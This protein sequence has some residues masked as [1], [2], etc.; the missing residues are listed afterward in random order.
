MESEIMATLKEW[1]KAATVQEQEQLAK[2]V[3]TNRNC[4]YQHA[5]VGAKY[6]RPIRAALARRLERESLKMHKESKGR[7]G[8]RL[9]IM[10]KHELAEQDECG[11][12]PCAKRCKESID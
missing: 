7:A 11:G 5:A 3:G 4:L 9:P 12:C 10:R 6:H 1:M 2:A 8:G